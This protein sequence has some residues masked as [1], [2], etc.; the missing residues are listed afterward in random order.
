[1]A[2]EDAVLIGRDAAM[3]V[4]TLWVIAQIRI[5]APDFAASLGIQRD[6][7]Q[8][9]RSGIEHAIHNDGIALH[10]RILESVMRVIGP[11]HLKMPDVIAIDLLQ[12]GITDVVRAAIN[13]PFDVG[14]L[15]Q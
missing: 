4:A 1:M 15:Y 5:E 7:T 9:R 3:P 6:Y 12:L 8:L 14:G 10:L 2:E 11:R 13:G